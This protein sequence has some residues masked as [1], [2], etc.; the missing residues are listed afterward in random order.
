VRLLVQVQIDEERP[1]QGQLLVAKLFYD[2][3][4]QRARS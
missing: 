1:H 4:F 2:H 3:A